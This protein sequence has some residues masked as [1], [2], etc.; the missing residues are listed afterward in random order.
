[1]IEGYGYV[2]LG[3]RGVVEGGGEDDG[4]AD[5]QRRGWSQLPIHCV[6]SRDGQRERNS[7]GADVVPTVDQTYTE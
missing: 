7:E 2:R 3:L 5:R 1:M 6:E 4:I